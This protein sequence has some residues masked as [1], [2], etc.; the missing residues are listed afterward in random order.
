MYS[1]EREQMQAALDKKILEEK[2]RLRLISKNNSTQLIDDERL[3]M[4]NYLP[5]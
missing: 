3:Q 1:Q 2:S 5:P 4:T